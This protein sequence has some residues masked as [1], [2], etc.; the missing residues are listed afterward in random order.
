MLLFVEGCVDVAVV[1]FIKI[2]DS[3]VSINETI[4]MCLNIFN[5]ILLTVFY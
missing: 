1:V 2:L 3:I 5:F 4:I